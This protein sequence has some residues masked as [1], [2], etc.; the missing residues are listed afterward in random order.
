MAK[1]DPNTILPSN[2]AY[3]NGSFGPVTNLPNSG[4]MGYA[5]DF[6]YYHGAAD[7]TRRPV[8]PFLLECPA[9]MLDTDDPA[10]WQAAL[11]ALIELHPRS[12]SGLDQSLDVEYVE[13]PFGGSGEMMQSLAKVRRARS[14]PQFEWVEKIGRPVLNFWQRYIIYFLGNPESNVPGIIAKGNITP[15]TSYPDYTAFTV[16]FVEPD[17]SQRYC[18]EAWLVTN[19]MPMQGPRNE[20]SRDIT[21]TP[22]SVTHSITFTGIQQVGDGVR[23]L[24]QQFLDRARQTGIDINTRPAFLQSAEADVAAA[25]T[26]YVEWMQKMSKGG[27]G[28]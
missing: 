4:M 6:R 13:N 16:L 2:T 12:I 9:A 11:K 21:A 25:D 22:E 24:G 15:G 26:G 20:G 27:V 18:Q 17:A 7:Y 10:K 23:K 14:V 1:K 28:I 3:V 8:I 5:P 19:M